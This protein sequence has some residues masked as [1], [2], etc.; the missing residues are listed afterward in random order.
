MDMGAAPDGPAHRLGYDG[1]VAGSKGEHRTGKLSFR[2]PRVPLQEPA[3]TLIQT[4]NIERIQR[5][6]GF[7][8]AG[9]PKALQRGPGVSAK[10]AAHACNP[11]RRNMAREA[12]E[13]LDADKRPK[14]GASAAT[15]L[16]KQPQHPKGMPDG[17]GIARPI[18]RTLRATTDK[19]EI[20]K[21]H[22]RAWQMADELA[23]NAG[24]EAPAM[25][26]DE[27]HGAAT[28]PRCVGARSPQERVRLAR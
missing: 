20:D 14:A 16:L 7:R 17:D 5:R 3:Q 26:E 6:K 13:A 9:A 2:T 27:A 24:M 8:A 1:V 22:L 28:A 10:L 4:L 21:G 23:P 15:P 25:D 11:R 18:A 12:V 19:A